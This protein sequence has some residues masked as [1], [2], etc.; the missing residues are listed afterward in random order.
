MKIHFKSSKNNGKKPSNYC[1]RRMKNIKFGNTFWSQDFSPL[2]TGAVV[3]PYFLSSTMRYCQG[4][5][6]LRNKEILKN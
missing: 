2:F 6:I 1:Y 5:N 4:K 3:I